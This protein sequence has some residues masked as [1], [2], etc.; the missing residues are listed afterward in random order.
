V[1]SVHNDY[2][3]HL[4][5]IWAAPAF[6]I[7]KFREYSIGQAGDGHIQEFLGDFGLSPLDSIGGRT[8]ADTTTLWITELWEFWIQTGD[9]AFLTEMWETAVGAINWQINV[10]SQIG[11]PWHLVCTYDILVLEAY[12]TTTYNSFL[13]LLAMRA[14][15]ELASVV[16]DAATKAKAD[17]AFNRA[18]AAVTALLWNS[19]YS[20]LRAYTGGDAIMSDAL[21]GQE[22]A[23][24]LGLGWLFDQG[25]LSKHLDAE[26]Q[27][28]GDAFGLKTITGRHKPPPY[29][30]SK[31]AHKLASPLGSFNP[32]TED[33]VIWEQ[34][35]PTWSSVRLAL[36]KA[37][38]APFT[39]LPPAAIT[40]ALEPTRK[41][42]E[43][44]RSRLNDLWNFAGIYTGDDWG[45]DG[46]CGMPFVTAHYGFT[47]VDFYLL[48]ALTGQQMNLAGNS[49]FL[50]F[51]P[52]YPC[53]YT[54]PVLLQG[55]EGTLVCEEA[56]TFT[57]SIKFGKLDLPQSGLR[58]NGKVYTLPVALRAGQSIT[59]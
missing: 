19:T 15:S 57:L 37:G 35:A 48:T 31:K 50:S 43:N 23:L 30:F 21:Y 14:A 11:L 5:Y 56:D 4:P 36:L 59:W 16:G 38:Q 46:V 25:S 47:M 2:Q 42:L 34:A 18:Q 20:Y 32:D 29:L 54:L 39:P 41:Q 6:E 27:Y 8:M 49:A 7:S 52:V 13:H 55:T 44:V 28:N 26:L 3:R 9:E 45:E 17:S 58:A 51:D 24:H 1:D 33:D 22:I 10:A 40:S 12:N 53:P